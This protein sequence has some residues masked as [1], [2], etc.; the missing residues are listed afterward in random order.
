MNS[1]A[2]FTESVDG[3]R[4]SVQFSGDLTLS[5][6]RDLPDRLDKL[7]GQPVLIDLS[8]VDRMDTIGAWL[9]HRLARDRDGQI[10]GTNEHFATL[11]EQVGQ[12][13]KS[14]K[15]RPDRTPPLYRVMNQVGGATAMAGRTMLGLLGFFG[16][17]LI[18]L[19]GVITHPRRFRLNA[20]TQQF[21]LL[22]HPLARH[23]RADELPRRASSSRS[24]ARSSCASSGG[25]LHREPRRPQRREGTRH[26]DDRDHGGRPLRIGL[27]G[28]DRLDEA[29]RGSGRD[30][31]IGLSP[32]ETLVIPAC[33]PPS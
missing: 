14:V 29:R 11:L 24:K 22:G 9:V 20:V 1:A 5:S 18:G 31:T 19:W 23:R 26:P 12:A 10:T 3:N 33:L 16:A 6:I 30:A 17:L 28:A 7:D 2:D 15:V 25:S 27:R 32:M 8:R 21:E 4:R 13:D